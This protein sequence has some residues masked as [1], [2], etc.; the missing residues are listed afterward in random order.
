MEITITEGLWGFLGV[1]AGGG[2]SVISQLAF[3]RSIAK[4][5]ARKI[6]AG[7]MVEILAYTKNVN[8]TITTL[9]NFSKIELEKIDNCGEL[10]KDLQRF[11]SNCVSQWPD[12]FPMLE[13]YFRKITKQKGFSIF[14]EIMDWIDDFQKRLHDFLL[15]AYDVDI[16]KYWQEEIKQILLK[17]ETTKNI[18]EHIRKDYFNK[19]H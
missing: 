12:Y 15:P 10:L 19:F 14:I 4:A 7:K 2:I 13:I 18:N 9:K 3:A 11:T 17:L 16:L 5:E 6:L 1:L 8:S